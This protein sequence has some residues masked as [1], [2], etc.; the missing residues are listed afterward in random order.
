MRGINKPFKL[1][2]VSKDYLW[3][4]TKLNDEFNLGLQASPLAEAWMCST[5][6]DGQSLVN[7]TPLGDILKEHPEYLG[8]HP[9][10]IT[11]GKAEL[12]ILFKLIDAT[13]DLSV[14]VH[15]DDEYALTHEGSR[16]KSEMW[17]VIQAGNSSE[18]IYGFKDDVDP[19]TVREAAKLGT[20]GEYLNHIPVHKDDV[21]FVESG[22]VHAIG[23]GCLVAEIQENSNI[24]YRLF[25]YNRIDKYGNRR[26]CHVDKAIE[27]AN[28]QAI[29]VPRQPLRVLKF[30]NGSASELLTRCKYFQV[31][32]LLLNT[33]SKRLA[34]YQTG[35][36]SFHV[37][38]CLEGC[39]IL[40]GEQIM[41]NFFKGDCIF[42]PACSIPLQLHGKAQFL[43]V[44]S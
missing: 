9:L 38:F 12:P 24:T 26:T 37:L 34:D 10:A 35:S 43:D 18:I 15:P 31:E 21:F 7:D 36:N 22:I 27:V 4:G 17:Y 5:H 23:A 40:F 39:G 33:E 2:P 1:E 44:S 25:D 28:L 20:I 30:K 14:Q 11:G 29:G 3:G 16:G 42:V 19:E 41:L 8:I 32:R 13:A 6:P